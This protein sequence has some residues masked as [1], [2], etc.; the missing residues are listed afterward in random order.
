MRT[1]RNRIGMLPGVTKLSGIQLHGEDLCTR[2][3]KTKTVNRKTTRRRN[4]IGRCNY[5]VRLY[6]NKNVTTQN[7]SNMK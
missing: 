5:C 1:V 6:T 2:I 3:E 4:A 7:H